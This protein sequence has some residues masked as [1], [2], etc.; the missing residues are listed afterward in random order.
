MNAKKYIL[1]EQHH[2]KIVRSLLQ[3][4][5]SL[6]FTTTNSYL[7]HHE[8]EDC[9]LLFCILQYVLYQSNWLS[10]VCLDISISLSLPPPYNLAPPLLWSDLFCSVS[11]GENWKGGGFSVCVCS[12]M[13][14]KCWLL[15]P[16]RQLREDDMRCCSA[17]TSKFVYH[18]P[19]PGYEIKEMNYYVFFL[20]VSSIVHIRFYHESVFQSMFTI[21]SDL[22]LLLHYCFAK[23]KGYLRLIFLP[24]VLACSKV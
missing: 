8:T 20:A 14:L 7:G 16:E 18:L 24:R 2:W 17:K 19:L 12:R 4:M 15:I 1:L 9:A 6:I 3:S 10:P 11:E 21:S 23:S 5:N 13:W 22:K